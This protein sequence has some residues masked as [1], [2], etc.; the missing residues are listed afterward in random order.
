MTVFSVLFFVVVSLTRSSS[1]FYFGAIASAL[2]VFPALIFLG[3]FDAAVGS[4]VPLVMLAII[5]ATLE[6]T[7]PDYAGVP[8]ANALAGKTALV[9]GGTRGIGLAV[10]RAYLKQ[11][12]RVVAAHFRTPLSADL[13]KELDAMGSFG[14]SV[15]LDLG[16]ADSIGSFV[17]RLGAGSKLGNV[18]FDIVVINS[19]TSCL[20][21]VSKDGYENTLNVNT[22]GVARLTRALLPLLNPKATV[23]FSS[24]AASRNW[25]GT[26]EE[27]LDLKSELPQFKQ[28]SI[29][30]LMDY[31][32][33]KAL[34]N[35]QTIQFA[36]TIP[37]VRFLSAFPLPTHTDMLLDAMDK[38]ADALHYPAF[39]APGT[40]AFE[41]FK[42]FWVQAL[43][44]SVDR[45]ATQYVYGAVSD[46]LPSGCLYF[47]E[48]C[49][50]PQP[51]EIAA[52]KLLQ[53][54]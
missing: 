10:T 3:W 28:E 43:S 14:G 35:A 45:V 20:K 15:T 29:R 49:L 11:G 1:V 54:V 33:S 37:N 16:S 26:V 12:A 36:T 17:E 46:A 8:S 24:S 13:Q 52:S 2:L 19:G 18:T 42:L 31:S 39:F 47:K 4:I 30:C 25:V 50:Q 38:L 44:R 23:I 7:D 51:I 6:Y 32:R 48:A 27:T 53:I 9:V 5:L 41:A 34:L 22:V 21:G 40:R